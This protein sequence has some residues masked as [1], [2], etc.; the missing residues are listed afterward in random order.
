[1]HGH[2][3]PAREFQ[4]HPHTYHNHEQTK[5]SFHSTRHMDQHL[6]KLWSALA[7]PE[8]AATIA[9]RVLEEPK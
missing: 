8:N 9:T 3:S 6:T 5:I 7:G 4:I 1:M 2:I